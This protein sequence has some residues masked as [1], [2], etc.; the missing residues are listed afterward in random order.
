[1]L[2]IDSQ[3][4]IFYSFDNC[5]LPRFD[6]SV[7]KV[8]LVKLLNPRPPP[9][10]TSQGPTGPCVTSNDAVSPFTS[11][12]AHG[13]ISSRYGVERTVMDRPRAMPAM[14][15]LRG[16]GACDRTLTKENSTTLLH[17]LRRYRAMDG[18]E[19]AFHYHPSG[20]SMV[21]TRAPDCF[22]S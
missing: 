3:R 20:A 5:S 15:L 13:C 6:A 14:L 22:M 18:E 19:N 8:R 7:D 2:V 11:C 10:E 1:M 4:F 16:L 21:Q 17:H 12:G 9:R